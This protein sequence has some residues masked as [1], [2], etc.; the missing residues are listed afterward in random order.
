MSMYDIVSV[1]SDGIAHAVCT[2]SIVHI[3]FFR[4]DSSVRQ[5]RWHMCNNQ[6]REAEET[7]ASFPALS[8]AHEPQPP[9]E[10]LNEGWAEGEAFPALGGGKQQIEGPG[11]KRCKIR[12]PNKAISDGTCLQLGSPKAP[13]QKKAQK[14]R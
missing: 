8:T 14:R 10:E 2:R 4:L 5:R 1:Q 3:V 12:D 13:P 7:A 6:R 11:A 9:P